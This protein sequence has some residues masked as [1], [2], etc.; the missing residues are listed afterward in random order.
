M[1]HQGGVEKVGTMSGNAFL[2]QRYFDVGTAEGAVG[3]WFSR[4]DYFVCFGLNRKGRFGGRDAFI[5]DSRTNQICPQTT[6]SRI[7]SCVQTLT[8]SGDYQLLVGDE[9]GYVGTFL[10][11]DVYG[12]LRYYGAANPLATEES[13]P[14]YIHSNLIAAQ[15]GLT[16]QWFVP[17]MKVVGATGNVTYTVGFDGKNRSEDPNLYSADVSRTVTTAMTNR[18]RVGGKRMQNCVVGIEFDAPTDGRVEW[19]GLEVTFNIQGTS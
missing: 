5:L 7:T 11:A 16:P 6:L 4:D 3:T 13:V 14:C 15:R 18:V 2:F 10:T 17:R 9:M 1:A 12:D 8:D 19:N